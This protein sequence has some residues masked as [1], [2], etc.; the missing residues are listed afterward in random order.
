MEEKGINNIRSFDDSNTIIETYKFGKTNT[1]ESVKLKQNFITDDELKKEGKSY[2]L[3]ASR[4]TAPF[5]CPDGA[6]RIDTSLLS[7]P[8]VLEAIMKIIKS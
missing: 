5:S 2:H 1:E 3:D 6:V 8:E 7:V 4:K